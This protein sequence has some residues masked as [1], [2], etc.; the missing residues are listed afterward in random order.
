MREDVP[1]KLYVIEVQ[2]AVK[3]ARAIARGEAYPAGLSRYAD[4]E[5]ELEG[6]QRWVYYY[7]R[8]TK[9]R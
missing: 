5:N 7:I 6:H 2:G 9:H 8:S 3:P 1:R 4:L